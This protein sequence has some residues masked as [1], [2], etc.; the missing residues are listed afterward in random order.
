MVTLVPNFSL[1]AYRPEIVFVVD[2]SG[3]MKRNIAT[4]I[5]AMK[6]HLGSLPIGV[7]FNICSFGLTYSLLWPKSM[8]YTQDNLAAA[9]RHTESFSAGM[10]GTEIFAAIEATIQQRYADIPCEIML[11]TDGDIW[12]PEKLFEYLNQQVELSKGSLRLFSL[13]IRDAVSSALIEGVARAGN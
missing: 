2:R 5:S 11:L 6:L 3:S 4:L 8:P 9:L 12:H 13:G 1:P 7:R 10:G